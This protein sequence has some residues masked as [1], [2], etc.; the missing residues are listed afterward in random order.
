MNNVNDILL[1]ADFAR[2]VARF[3]TW[4]ER[5][6]VDEC[7]PWRISASAKN[8][9]SDYGLFRIGHD[10]KVR[11]T[12][13]RIAWVLANGP[14][15]DGLYVLH[16]CDNPRCVNPKHLFLGTHAENQADKRAKGRQSRGEENGARF[17]NEQILAMRADPRLYAD[18]AADYGTDKAHVGLVKRGLIWRHVGGERQPNKRRGEQHFGALLDPDKVR[19]IRTHRMDPQGFADLYGVVRSTI[20]SVQHWVTWKHVK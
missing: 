19:D 11:H 18:I 14:I 2:Q 8:G 9:R 12:S 16:R 5:R 17:T 6:G 13:H 15:P 20:Y 7:W 1:R 10:G 3:H 4:Y